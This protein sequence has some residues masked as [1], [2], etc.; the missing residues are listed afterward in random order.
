MSGYTELQKELLDALKKYQRQFKTTAPTAGKNSAIISSEI[1]AILQDQSLQNPIYI[2]S[3]FDEWYPSKMID[4]PS[5]SWKLGFGGP[6]KHLVVEGME[7]YLKETLEKYPK[8]KV[9]ELK[10]DHEKAEAKAKE[11]ADARAKKDKEDADAKAK[12]AQEEAEAAERLKKQQKAEAKEKEK[13][14]AEL[15]R[16]QEMEALK[17][18]IEKSTAQKVGEVQQRVEALEQQNQ[19]LVVVNTKLKDEN[20][21]YEGA[22][23]VFAKRAKTD[24]EFRRTIRACL[25]GAGFLRLMPAG[26]LE[27]D[28]IAEDFAP[29]E[30]K[31][32]RSSS[33]AGHPNGFHAPHSSAKVESEEDAVNKKLQLA[34]KMLR[35]FLEPSIAAEKMTKGSDNA[36]T[37][38][39]KPKD[40]NNI[41]FKPRYE[42]VVDL[43]SYIAQKRPST[44]DITIAKIYIGSLLIYNYLTFTN[45]TTLNTDG[46]GFQALHADLTRI[47]SQQGLE[48]PTAINNFFEG[49]SDDAGA[50]VL[51]E[52]FRLSNVSTVF[53]EGTKLRPQNSIT[54]A[55]AEAYMQVYQVAEECNVL[56]D[57]YIKNQLQEIAAAVRNQQK[58]TMPAFHRFVTDYIDFYKTDLGLAI[59]TRPTNGK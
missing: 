43:L 21:M 50:I 8:A 39:I 47:L 40:A 27:E 59:V 23:T 30:P 31:K 24:L 4:T 54:G 41:D 48:I 7:K 18:S 9:E 13:Q 58:Y 26:S 29:D 49:R 32:K 14:Q 36:I 52:K 46:K 45:T 56:T 34:F 38:S 51:A 6:T 42:L 35:T 5:S 25:E 44:K 15:L 3:Q 55:Q 2:L 10:K 19:Q 20:E 11:E 16:K 37:L 17:A 1:D 53:S 57:I 12:Q 28:E 22:M 33:V